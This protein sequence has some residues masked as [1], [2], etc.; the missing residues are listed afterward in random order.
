MLRTT[1]VLNPF[2]LSMNPLFVDAVLR[3][4]LTSVLR[5]HWRHT[6]TTRDPVQAFAY[7]LVLKGLRRM[8]KSVNNEWLDTVLELSHLLIEVV[9]AH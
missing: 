4:C 6:K 5:N 9:L 8:L 7:A 3:S 2:T 1:T